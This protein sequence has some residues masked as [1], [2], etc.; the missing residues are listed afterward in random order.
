MRSMRGLL[1]MA[2]GASLLVAS[3]AQV[4][5]AAPSEQTAVRIGMSDANVFAPA[6]VTVAPGTTVTW[7]NNGG[8]H[9]SQSDGR[10]DS[11]LLTAAGATFSFTFNTPGTYSY[12]CLPHRA[13]GM[14]GTITVAGAQAAPAAAGAQPSQLPR[15]GDAEQPVN[16]IALGGGLALIAAGLWLK[17]RSRRAEGA[18]A[19]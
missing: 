2:A 5:L 14:V 4:A 12:Y 18:S 16:N 17:L 6:A 3:M 7:V 11:G 8:V 9:S 1:V 10:W 19:D 13:L 15:T